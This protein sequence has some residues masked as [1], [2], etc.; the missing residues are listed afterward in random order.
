[1]KSRPE[2]AL[3]LFKQDYNCCQSVLSAFGPS[4]GLDKSLCLKLGAGF[5]AGLGYQGETCGAVIGAYLVLGLLA[6][7]TTAN[8]ELRKELTNGLIRGFLSE[9]RKTHRFTRCNDL[10]GIRIETP[11]G[12][13]HA[14]ENG[15]FS[16][17]CPQF[18]G[19]ASVILEKLIKKY[20]EMKSE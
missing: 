20:S 11:E 12:F 17:R 16:D 2:E 3:V 19:E 15:L 5:P 4:L 8:D 6:G 1:M 18:V 7:N 14:V 13:D 10:L 9:F